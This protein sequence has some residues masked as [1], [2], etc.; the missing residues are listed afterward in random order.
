MNQD[1]S[2]SHSIFTIVIETSQPNPNDASKP[3]IR[4]GKLN[5]V[6]LAGSER[7]GKTGA[8]G[9]RLKEATKINLSLSALGNCISALVDGKS[10][11]V[12]YRDSKLTRMLEDSLGGNTKT[13][14]IATCGPADYNYDETLSTL[15]YAS[16]AKCIKNKPRINE[17]PKDTMLREMQ[18]EIARLKA[19]IA[20]QADGK[21]IKTKAPRAPKAPKAP[22]EKKEKKEKKA[23]KKK[24]GN[25][26]A[27]NGGG[28]GGE[29]GAEGGDEDEDDDAEE[30]TESGEEETDSE[31][32]E[33]E[34]AAEKKR[35]VEIRIIEEI[36]EIQGVSEEEAA[37]IKEQMDA[38]REALETKKREEEELLARKAE[39]LAQNEQDLDEGDAATRALQE[40]LQQLEDKIL[41]NEGLGDQNAALELELRKRQ[42]ETEQLRLEEQRLAEQLAEKEEDLHLQGENYATLEEAVQFKTELLEKRFKQYQEVKTDIMDIQEEYADEREDLLDTIRQMTRDLKLSHAI[43]ENFIPC[44][45]VEKMEERC[46]W[47]DDEEK[48]VLAKRTEEQGLTIR[49]ARPVS[50]LGT[51]SHTTRHSLINAAR[52]NSRH[53]SENIITLELDMPARTTV[54]YDPGLNAGYDYQYEMQNGMEQDYGYQ[55][56]Y[57]QEGYQEDYD[58]YNGGGYSQPYSQYG[59]ED[60]YAGYGEPY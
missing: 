11:H 57:A 46:K 52:G 8:T 48:W 41:H 43:I 58:P 54:D 51:R 2:R 59:E 3:N 16:R 24:T 5:L 1:S 32:E 39:E 13:C 23:K 20:A 25:G 34:G 6:D 12:P 15:R 10:S 31:E 17:D 29:A 27:G 49:A 47:D 40:Q 26:G 19:A 14:M 22:K 4:A 7:Q 18:E 35:E 56:A 37:R 9:E 38:E 30:E 21:P 55:D 33:G 36:V 44:D 45:D 53:K 28:V 42:A 60:L 50:A